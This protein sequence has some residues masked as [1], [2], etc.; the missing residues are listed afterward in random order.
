VTTQISELP[1]PRSRK[2]GGVWEYNLTPLNP[3]GWTKFP[4]NLSVTSAL[5]LNGA[6]S[7]RFTAGAST[8]ASG[9]FQYKA[10]DGTTAGVPGSRKSTAGT[11]VSTKIETATFS[12]GNITPT[13]TTGVARNFPSTKEN[14]FP[15]DVFVKKVVAA[16]GRRFLPPKIRQETILS[17]QPVSYLLGL[18][19][20][21]NVGSLKGIAIHGSVESMTH[22]TLGTTDGAW[23]YMND[24]K[25]WQAVGDV[26]PGSKLLLRRTDRLRFVPAEDSYGTVSISYSAWDQT[27]GVSGD[28]LTVSGDSVGIET[29]TS[30]W[31]VTP[32]T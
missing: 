13:F 32:K 8:I 27:A 2:R 1:S 26:T 24:G 28:R 19:S 4:T 16:G 7:V 11:S 30:D 12:L 25:T 9:Q 10:W 14:E 23:E 6:S 21:S 20:D 15:K 22:R 18:F 3:Q 5:L 17:G 29:L 31:V